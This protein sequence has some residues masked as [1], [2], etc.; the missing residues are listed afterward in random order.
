MSPRVFA[1]LP[2]LASPLLAAEL[3]TLRLRPQTIDPAIQIGYG[4]AIAD[5]DGDGRPD[6]LL[7][8]AKQIVWYRAPKWEKFVMAE[9]LTPKDNVCIA[10][11][12]L[13]GDSKA[14]VAVGAEWNPGDT[15][16]S[17]AI[18]LLEAP[19]DRTQRWTP[20]R[21]PHEPTTHRMHWL[22]GPDRTFML[23]VLPLHGRGNKNGAGAGVEL[24]GYAWPWTA[25]SHP[26]PLMAAQPPLHLTHNFDVVP[27]STATSGETLLLA[28]KEGVFSIDAPANRSSPQPVTAINSGEVRRGAL[29]GGGRYLATIEPMHGHELA[30]Y[31]APASQASSGHD[32]TTSRTL[33]DGKLIQGHGLAT[34]D[35]LGVGSDQIVVG[36]R[37]A[38]A[39]DRVG[40][41][42]YAATDAAGETWTMHAL[43]DDNQMAC[44]DLKIADLDGDGRPD[45]IAAGRA[46]KNV[47]IYWN[48]TPK[49]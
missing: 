17:G 27:G 34:G 18:F 11:R 39:G 21:L 20:R 22:R 4:L 5:V 6:I 12:D 37:G 1:L 41:K 45:I 13:D 8:D 43:I 26:T 25:A 9:N 2:F 36:W 38:K 15:T 7:A 33:L 10:A 49:R 14:E 24:H 30:V 3:P 23:A 31:R 48:E 19:A 46:T 42:L 35:L 32:L 29:P 40:L 28:T 16:G 47:I 44:E